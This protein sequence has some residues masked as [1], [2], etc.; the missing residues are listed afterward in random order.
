MAEKQSGS[1][2]E[3]QLK[4]NLTL[5]IDPNGLVSVEGELPDGRSFRF[6]GGVR[7]W[8][9]GSSNTASNIVAIAY[10]NDLLE[11]TNSKVE[12]KMGGYK[13]VPT[14]QHAQK[15]VL[16]PTL[17]VTV[18]ENGFISVD[19]KLP[20]TGYKITIKDGKRIPT[21][22]QSEARNHEIITGLNQILSAEGQQV[23]KEAEGFKMVPLP[24]NVE[25]AE[26]KVSG[27]EAKLE[28]GGLTEARQSYGEQLRAYLAGS[29]KVGVDLSF[30]ASR[31]LETAKYLSKAAASDIEDYMQGSKESVNDIVDRGEGLA[32]ETLSNLRVKAGRAAGISSFLIRGSVSDITDYTYEA[33]PIAKELGVEAWTYAKASVVVPSTLIGMTAKT[34]Y[35]VS[36]AKAEEALEYGYPKASYIV[37][38]SISDIQDY[39]NEAWD[40]TKEAVLNRVDAEAWKGRVDAAV[41]KGRMEAVKGTLKSGE[42]DQRRT[43]PWLMLGQFTRLPGSLVDKAV[44]KVTGVKNPVMVKRQEIIDET[45]LVKEIIGKYEN[46]ESYAEAKEKALTV[47]SADK[48]DGL[49]HREKV[50]IFEEAVYQAQLE[51]EKTRLE[52]E[53]SKKKE[54]S[55]KEKGSKTEKES[56][57]LKKGWGFPSIG[58]WTLGTAATVGIGTAGTLATVG[59]GAGILAHRAVRLAAFAPGAAL[60]LTGTLTGSLF[61]GIAETGTGTY[62]NAKGAGSWLAN[63]LVNPYTA[64]SPWYAKAARF[65]T[66]TLIGLPAGIIASPFTF[67]YAG[68]RALFENTTG[69][70]LSRTTKQIGPYTK[71]RTKVDWADDRGLSGVANNLWG[72]WIRPTMNIGVTS[73]F[74]TSYNEKAQKEM[75][76]AKAM[77]MGERV[78]G[79]AAKA[80]ATMKGF[81]A[82]DTKKAIEVAGKIDWQTASQKVIKAHPKWREK[83][84]YAPLLV[85]STLWEQETE[86][87]KEGIDTFVDLFDLDEKFMPLAWASNLLAV[88]KKATSKEAV[89]LKEMPVRYGSIGAQLLTMRAE[90][91]V[92]KLIGF[93]KSLDL[94]QVDGEDAYGWLIGKDTI[95]SIIDHSKSSK[96]DRLNYR[97]DVVALFGG[98]GSKIGKRKMEDNFTYLKEFL[99]ASNYRDLDKGIALID[100]VEAKRMQ[101]LID[102]MKS[103]KDEVYNNYDEIFKSE[104][105]QAA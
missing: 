91:D 85:A 25:S 87:F 22:Q 11:G 66:R 49:G 79:W 99:D 34:A 43:Y 56:E 15:A 29:T 4:N 92:G 74:F 21:G 58:P 67:A 24:K 69:A 2:S 31:S 3:I 64:E 40:R 32:K 47:L 51:M 7:F 60:K 101:E 70:Y 93:I 6:K 36:K 77:G 48:Y 78:E 71:K 88:A 98:Q 28:F 83:W 1:Q 68:G 61:G 26:P 19:G 42:V 59:M 62:Q 35:E 103:V 16:S 90:G 33:L 80:W 53:K 84:R 76:K 82:L 20:L 41:W 52:A 5:D 50:A 17:E 45:D 81:T 27:P 9:T 38:G 46:N 86:L 102:F 65:S 44:E 89:K 23:V 57:K 8:P 12:Y 94:S 10:L 95:S 100:I 55:S 75:E 18:D 39:S 96:R 54:K 97:K 13:L 73:R 105:R 72:G 30:K 37:R 104:E 63:K 14:S